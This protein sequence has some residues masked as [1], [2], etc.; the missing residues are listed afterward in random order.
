[1]MC[2]FL[3]GHSRQG[4]G[5]PTSRMSPGWRC[6]RASLYADFRGVQEKVSESYA[7]P[8]ASVGHQARKGA[9]GVHDRLLIKSPNSCSLA[10]IVNGFLSL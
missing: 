1:M 4:L 7:Q 10:F 3:D 9:F 6:V 5:Y 8:V 2:S